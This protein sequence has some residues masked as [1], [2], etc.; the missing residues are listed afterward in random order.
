[1]AKLRKR[2]IFHEIFKNQASTR[3]DNESPTDSSRS[4]SSTSTRRSLD[5]KTSTE[6]LPIIPVSLTNMP[7]DL[8]TPGLRQKDAGYRRKKSGDQS[9]TA[10][11]IRLVKDTTNYALQKPQM[12]ASDTQLNTSPNLAGFQNPTPA[13]PPTPS[14]TTSHPSNYNP[15]PSAFTHKTQ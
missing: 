1:M 10:A 2:S 15:A 14:G 9:T 5:D 6:T 4:S 8:K 12:V 3:S 7:L 13:S 11:T